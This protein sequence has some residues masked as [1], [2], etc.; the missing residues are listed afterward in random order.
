MRLNEDTRSQTI[1]LTSGKRMMEEVQ[2]GTHSELAGKWAAPNDTF[3]VV[4]LTPQD[5]AAQVGTV[6][7]TVD[8]ANDDFLDVDVRIAWKS[9]TGN[10]SFQVSRKLVDERGGLS[11]GD[12]GVKFNN[13]DSPGEEATPSS[14][15]GSGGGVATAFTSPPVLLYATAPTT[16]PPVTT[17]TTETPAPTEPTSNGDGGDANYSGHDDDSDSNGYCD[18]CGK[19]IG[20]QHLGNCSRRGV[21]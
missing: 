3:P 16:T 8:P 1:A 7:I 5:G 21:N 17:E 12:T 9:K 19:A 14:A 20:S 2:S 6:T 10:R 15:A 18:E 4:G 11:W 13:A